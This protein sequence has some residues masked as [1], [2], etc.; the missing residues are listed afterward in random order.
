ME[1][2]S[3]GAWQGSPVQPSRASPVDKTNFIAYI[4][5]M[6]LP[7]IHFAPVIERI[8]NDAA[9]VVGIAAILY[10]IIKKISSPAGETGRPFLKK[11]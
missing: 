3:A 10:S 7:G 2:P 4:T 9:S 6:L 5:G 8:V 1:C 11:T